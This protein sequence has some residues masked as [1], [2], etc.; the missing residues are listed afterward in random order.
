MGLRYFRQESFRTQLMTRNVTPSSMIEYAAG[1]IRDAIMLGKLPPGTPL[2]RRRL[3]EELAVSTVPVTQAL[4]RLES[5]GLASFCSET[6]DN[7]QLI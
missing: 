5:E 2:S 1:R 6:I 4:Q 3:A 7:K